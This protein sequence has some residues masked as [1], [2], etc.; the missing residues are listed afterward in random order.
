MIPMIADANQRGFSQLLYRQTG[1]VNNVSLASGVSHG[2]QFSFL[3]QVK[4][5]VP[6]CLL[7]AGSD[8]LSAIPQSLMKDLQGVSIVCLSQ[9]STLTTGA[10]DVVIPTALP[11]LECGGSVVRMDGDVVGLVGPLKGD[12]FTEEA[13]LRQLAERT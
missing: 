9:F 8:P 6:Q 5:H 11:G 2:R 10:A 13:V 1:H 4:N 7:V 3:E 12:Y